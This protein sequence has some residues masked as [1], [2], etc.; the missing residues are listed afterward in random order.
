MS[1]RRRVPSYPKLKTRCSARPH[2]TKGLHIPQQPEGEVLDLLVSVNN[3]FA[4]VNGV[5]QLLH[6]NIETRVRWQVQ[7]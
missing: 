2:R 7:L 5:P 4:V 3:T 1:S 6:Q